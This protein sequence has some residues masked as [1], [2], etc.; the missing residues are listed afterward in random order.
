MLS[1]KQQA[2]TLESYTVWSQI[3]LIGKEVKI[4]YDVNIYANAYFG[5]NVVLC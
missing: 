2:L 5:G 3:F 1:E 4:D